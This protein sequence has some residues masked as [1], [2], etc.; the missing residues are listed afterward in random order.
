MAYQ[1]QLLFEG[2]IS[3]IADDGS[4]LKRKLD[5]I[6]GAL[7]A[8]PKLGL[9]FGIKTT[10]NYWSAVFFNGDNLDG[11]FSIKVQKNLIFAKGEVV[12][13][14]DKLPPKIGKSVKSNE[15]TIELGG[16]Y[17]AGEGFIAKQGIIVESPILT[18][19]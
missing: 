6:S 17:L 1:F 10:G 13:L 7:K 16:F 5:L 3:L 14:V 2:Q 12:I 19:V 11:V 8:K 9:D 15:Y 4:D 18:L